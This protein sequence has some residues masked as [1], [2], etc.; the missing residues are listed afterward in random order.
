MV[1]G[2]DLG[3]MRGAERDRFRGREIG[4]VFQ[5]LHLLPT[6]TL[7]ENLLLA[8]YMAGVP[9]DAVRVRE[10]LAGAGLEG[11]ERA[12]PSET[13]HGQLQRAAIARAVL[14]SPSVILADEPTSNLDDANAARVLDLL[15]S[16]AGDCE[17]TLIIA[18]HDRRVVDRFDDRLSLGAATAGAGR[19]GRE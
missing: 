8:Q 14:H 1:A 2:R 12:Y 15:I 9:R 18:T 19:Q 7:T 17:A 11:K 5:Q 4:I 13:S 3:E 6:L 16:R 10:A